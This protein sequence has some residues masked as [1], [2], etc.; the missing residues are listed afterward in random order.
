[1]KDISCPECGCDISGDSLSADPARRRYFAILRDAWQ[2]LRPPYDQL[3]PSP[4]AMRKHLLC[5]VGWCD[6]T[7][8]ASGSKS[9]AINIADAMRSLDRYAVIEV[10]GDIITIHRA[11]SQSRKAQPKAQFM[12]CADRIY[13]ELSGILGTDLSIDSERAA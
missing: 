8:V 7:Q 4:E 3:W 10:R 6:T 12:A 11:R 9:A 1:M 2:N 5:R 13:G